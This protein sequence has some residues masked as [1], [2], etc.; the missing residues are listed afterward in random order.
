MHKY[1]QI[2]HLLTTRRANEAYGEG[3]E[4]GLVGIFGKGS[5]DARVCAA[6]GEY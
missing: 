6:N 5:V 1:G 2:S 3:S 4:E